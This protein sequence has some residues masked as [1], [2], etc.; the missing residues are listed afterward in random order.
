MSTSI[1]QTRQECYICRAKYNVSTVRGLE[2]HRVAFILAQALPIRGGLAGGLHS[3]QPIG[4]AGVTIQI[5]QYQLLVA[6]ACSGLNSIISLS[7]ITLFYIYIRHQADLRCSSSIERAVIRQGM[8]FHH[9][10]Q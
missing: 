5:G 8:L 4:G 10:D 1:M 7:A 2:E 3:G 9:A 6:A